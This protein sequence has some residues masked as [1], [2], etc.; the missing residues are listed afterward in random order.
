MS[1]GRD[2]ADHA[3]QFWLPFGISH[4]TTVRLEGKLTSELALQESLL[5]NF[6]ASMHSISG[7]HQ[8]A[9]IDCHV[10]VTPDY[11]IMLEEKLLKW[12]QNPRSVTTSLLSDRSLDSGLEGLRQQTTPNVK[13]TDHR[14]YPP[15]P[16]D[17][18]NRGRAS[19]EEI[20]RLQRS[21]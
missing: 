17:F 21:T 11:F 10:V 19:Q 6:G 7:L 2:L 18:R 15:S 16:N 1:F 14:I 9:T 12:W 8:P 20:K 5:R 3:R 13:D 4:I